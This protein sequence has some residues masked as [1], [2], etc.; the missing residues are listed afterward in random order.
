[1]DE[2][3]ADVISVIDNTR[4]FVGAISQASALA[5]LLRREHI[6]REEM[7]RLQVRVQEQ[8]DHLAQYDPL[9]GLPNRVLFNDRLRQATIAAG[10]HDRVVTVMFLDLDRFKTINDT[11]GHDAGDLVLM[12]VAERLTACI[13]EGDTVARLGGDEYGIVL[14]DMAQA[15]DAVLVAQKLLDCFVEPFIVGERE[16]FV[17]AS[18]GITLYPN[19]EPRSEH[20]LK[21]A[22]CALYRAKERGRNTYYIYTPD[23]HAEAV[24]RLTMET[25]LRRALERDE[26]RL[27]FQPQVDLRSG[28]LIGV[29]ALVR[30]ERPGDGLV[31][32]STFIAVAED[33]GLIVPIGEW[34][35]RAACEQV[36]AW[37][38]AG[39]APPRVS[40]NVSPRQFRQ[41]GFRDT[42]QAVLDCTRLSPGCLEIEITESLMIEHIATTATF[43]D[44][45]AMG[46]SIA[47]DDFGMGYS[48]LGYLKR[49]PIDTIK[50]DRWFISQTG[51]DL[52]HS[53]IVSAI[54]SLAHT[55]RL[56]VIAE[57]VETEAQAAFLRLQGCDGAQGY[58]FSHPRSAGELT[59]MLRAGRLLD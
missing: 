43:K 49:F 23:M 47:I 9:T 13:R 38:D 30:W 55:L 10:R 32:P 41:K 54:I 25:H 26:F 19:D 44:L 20:L 34:I 6:G 53:A 52:D 45:H 42:V 12:A 24:G 31:A 2:V 29:E 33:T 40:I 36:T 14:T 35:M 7:R 51:S 15:Q 37:H 16:L 3:K 28:R 48:S 58:L 18:I 46:I 56:K 11:L 21:N 8:L 39:F 4:A 59:A 17:T 5:A 1:M 22:D 57:G 50:I 27:H